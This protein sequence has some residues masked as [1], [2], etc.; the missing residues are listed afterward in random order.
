MVLGGGF[1][2]LCGGIM[3]DLTL[4]ISVFPNMS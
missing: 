4:F 3:V 2:G 1:R